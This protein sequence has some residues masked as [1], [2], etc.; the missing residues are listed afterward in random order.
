MIWHFNARN[1]TLLVI[2]IAFA[3]GF[4]PKTFLLLLSIFLIYLFIPLSTEA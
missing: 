1:S 3:W 2:F 4:R